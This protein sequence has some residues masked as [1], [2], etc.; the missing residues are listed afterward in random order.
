[1]RRLNRDSLLSPTF[2]YE[3]ISNEWAADAAAN[4]SPKPLAPT[5]LGGAPRHSMVIV[6]MDSVRHSTALAKHGDDDVMPFVRARVRAGAEVHEMYTVVPNTNKAVLPLVC[7]MLPDSST[8]WDECAPLHSANADSGLACTLS[9]T[10]R[11]ATPR[12]P[13][14]SV[15]GSA[16]VRRYARRNLSECLPSVLRANGYRTALFAPGPLEPWANACAKHSDIG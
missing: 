6:V 9:A 3:A 10:N 16:A 7:G 1:V 8:T 15:Q 12:Q 13:V 4:V 2:D 14:P 5:H 11:A